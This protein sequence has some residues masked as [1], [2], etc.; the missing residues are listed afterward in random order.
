[1][2]TA[3]TDINPID[4]KVILSNSKILNYDK[5]ILANGGYNFIPPI[6]G[7]NNDGVFTLRNLKDAEN[8]KTML[9]AKHATVIGGDY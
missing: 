1:M 7:T 8:I 9:K 3:V 4:K 5:L 2:N 6:K